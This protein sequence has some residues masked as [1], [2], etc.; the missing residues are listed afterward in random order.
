MPLDA[1]DSAALKKA[2][3]ELPS[4]IVQLGD[5]PGLG[6][7]KIEV[8]GSLKTMLED[9]LQKKVYET[10]KK[11]ADDKKFREFID[12]AVERNK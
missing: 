2:K 12:A 3:T 6:S 8:M 1:D 9:Q 7:P 4:E 11:L 10:E 5:T